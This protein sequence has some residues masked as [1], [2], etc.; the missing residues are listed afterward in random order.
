ML[1]V[2]G[3]NSEAVDDVLRGPPPSAVTVLKKLNGEQARMLLSYMA[4]EASRSYTTAWSVLQLVLAIPALGILL[5]ER[6]TRYYTIGVALM[7]LLVLFEWLVITPQL[8]WLGRTVDFVPW[9]TRSATRD[10]YWNLRAVYLGMEILKI[11][12]GAGV[13]V[14][15]VIM[16]SRPRAVT[17]ELTQLQPPEEGARRRRTRRSRSSGEHTSGT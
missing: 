11:L 15:L 9:K 2:T 7:L 8:D 12:L 4:D 14:M 5:M 6:R 13:T 10:Q 17:A 3:V 16:R 1:L